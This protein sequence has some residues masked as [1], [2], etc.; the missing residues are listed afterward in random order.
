MNLNTLLEAH[1]KRSPINAL[2]DNLGDGYLLEKN[3]LY[4][5]IRHHVLDAGFQLNQDYHNPYT[6]LPLAQLEELLTNKEIVYFNNVSV[7]TSLAKKNDLII[8][9][10]LSDILK[11]NYIFHESCH[12]I[13][14]SVSD[15]IQAFPEKDKLIQF[16]L[17]E[18][19]ANTCELMALV[20]CDD[21]IHRIFYKHNSY[22]SLFEERTHLKNTIHLVGEEQLFK[23]LMLCYLYSHFLF[24]R[25]DE[26]SFNGILDLVNLKNLTPQAL[27]S[28]KYLSK[29]P[30][31][32]DL[33]FR[34]ITA[35][36]FLKLHRI[37]TDIEKTDFIIR[38]QKNVMF[39][40]WLSE[41]C[42]K[43]F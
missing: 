37:N 31:T 4:R 13:A 17:E 2:K 25:L 18:S 21:V 12:A 30:F 7:L 14:R 40:E 16:F 24:N 5:N 41:V 10:D 9:E 28:L 3:R 43:C 42:R 33:E 35:T 38:L 15:R 8:W 23:F 20:D 1:I 26:K 32:L 27:K 36:L 39:S 22:T 19:F 6:V 29:I 11:K 34:T